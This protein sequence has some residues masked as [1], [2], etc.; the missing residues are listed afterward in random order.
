MHIFSC[1]LQACLIAFGVAFASAVAYAGFVLSVTDIYTHSWIEKLQ[2][3]PLCI[4][5]VTAP[6]L[7]AIMFRKFH[8]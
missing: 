4:V 2:M 6:M 7:W 1:I 3:L 5:A 8:G